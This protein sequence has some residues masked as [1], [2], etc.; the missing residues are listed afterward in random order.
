MGCRKTACFVPCPE[1]PL[2]YRGR[3][4][5]HQPGCIVMVSI[6]LIHR[7]SPSTPALW[8]SSIVVQAPSVAL[9]F[10]PIK[11][12]P[13]SRLESNQHSRGYHTCVRKQRKHGC[14]TG[15][16]ACEK[17]C[18]NHLSKLSSRRSRCRLIATTLFPTRSFALERKK[19]NEG[20][21]RLLGTLTCKDEEEQEKAFGG[22]DGFLGREVPC[23]PTC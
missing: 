12:S 3:A 22:E 1:H 16:C 17:M 13:H 19:G 15:L 20:R 8:C 5:Q 2:Q 6:S 7:G 11:R 21:P 10:L 18:P 4:T 23:V 14:C 9:C